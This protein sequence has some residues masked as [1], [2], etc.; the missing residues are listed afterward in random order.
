MKKF[1]GVLFAIALLV[2]FL[3]PAS[4]QVQAQN[5]EDET[6]ETGVYI[7]DVDVSGL[8]EEEAANKVQEYINQIGPDY[9]K[10]H[11]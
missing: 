5:T 1:T 10:R 6:I 11:E 8:T 4:M 9:F 3:G 2:L 7:G